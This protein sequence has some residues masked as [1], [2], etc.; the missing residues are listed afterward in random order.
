MTPLEHYIHHRGYKGEDPERDAALASLATLR[1]IVAEVGA[2][3][4]GH[5]SDGGECLY[6]DARLASTDDEGRAYWSGHT[7]TCLVT[8]ARALIA[9][10]TP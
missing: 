3:P 1:A 4:Y 2:N 6:Y 7:P 5:L 10:P 9:P 8:R